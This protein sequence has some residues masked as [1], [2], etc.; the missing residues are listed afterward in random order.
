MQAR[1][2]IAAHHD[3]L[4][5]RLDI[6]KMYLQNVRQ[7]GA[8][9]EG[10]PEVK[11]KKVKNA[12]KRFK[13]DVLEKSGVIAKV[14]GDGAMVRTH[15]HTEQ[16]DMVHNNAGRWQRPQ[17]YNEEGRLQIHRNVAVGIPGAQIAHA[18]THK[19]AHRYKES[20][21]HL[22]T[23]VEVTLKKG[24]EISLLDKPLTLALDNL[25]EMDYRNE[26]GPLPLGELFSPHL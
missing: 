25:L 9:R 13:F 12:S 14:K 23:Q 15:I 8:S 1:D 11:K 2:S 17:E 10:K 19:Y 6:Y 3:Y 16:Y 22:H 21:G 24:L 4:Q 7:G 18:H 5:S 20:P 26:V